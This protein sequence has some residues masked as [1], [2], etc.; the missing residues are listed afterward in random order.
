MYPT[1]F[2]PLERGRLRLRNRT[3]FPGHQTLYSRD[4][5]ISDRLRRY[6]VERAR[7]GVGAVVVEGG[8]VHPTTLKFP[9]YLRF[10]DPEVMPSVA[11]LVEELAEHDTR[12]FVQ[13][14]HSGSRM[15]TMD[16]RLPLWAP[17]DVRSANAVEIPHA[18]THG[19][20]RELLDGYRRSAGL[21]VD[22]GADGVEV[23]AAHEYLLGEFLS[24]HNN[25]REDEYGGSLENRARL[26]LEVIE[27]VRATVG[28]DVV[29]G[30]RM[31]GH[32]HRP[33]GNDN[34]AYVEVA[35]MLD[36]TGA[37]DYVSVTAGT[38]ADNSDIVPPMA[39]PRGV[40]VP[41]A[42]AI[43]AAVEHAAVFVV[44]RITTPQEAEEVLAAG[45][46]DVVAMARALIADPEALAKARDGH[47]DRIRP[48]VGV[49]DGCYG[50]LTAVRPISCVVNPAVGREDELGSGTTTPA[51]TARRI[52][53]I[54]GGPAGL[55]A[56]RVAAERGHRVTLHEAA[57]QLG[58]QL[59]LASA[60]P[61]RGD[62]ARL[63][64][65][66]AREV[67]RLGVDVRLGSRVADLAALEADVVVA[68][69]GSVARPLDVPVADGA[70]VL[71][72]AE[73]VA[74]AAGDVAG[75]DV[76]VVDDVGHMPAYVPAELL[77]AAGAGV[78]VVSSSPMV[79]RA[80]EETTRARTIRRLRELG[81]QLS[82]GTA[83]DAVAA[84]AVEVH[85]VLHRTPRRLPADIV[86]AAVPNRVPAPEEWLAVGDREVHV[87][88]DAL[89]PRTA[90]E[91]VR[92]GQLLGRRL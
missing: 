87:I 58:G 9:D 68:A 61:S 57:E 31:N 17:S 52:A 86:V 29:V 34:A 59:Q 81:V 63:V 64:R 35:R 85:D 12:T 38:S 30:V 18:M 76:V 4:G 83:V 25:R 77:A 60:A 44:G 2:S 54:G 15:G 80:L 50:R 28:D 72:V 3:V 53:V 69:T 36:A 71:T 84:D 65:F 78:T 20:I 19:D 91:A 16:S 41:D 70:I 27:A 92:E 55:E 42:S 75:R 6:Y 46:A 67:E 88:G 11:R 47:A 24:P 56:A 73:A 22:A 8:A 7:G 33:D 62:L 32:D 37:V 82:T 66:L 21:V 14:A 48:C 43:T 26:L 89:A 1:L 10:Y 13:L 40:N 23:H 51:G 90:L 49:N 39:V 5:A 79:G 74:A 45:H